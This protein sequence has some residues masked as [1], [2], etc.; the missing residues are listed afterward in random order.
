MCS[1][2]VNWGQTKM[3][4]DKGWSEDFENIQDR[5][6]TMNPDGATVQRCP[7]LMVV[8]RLAHLAMAGSS[9]RPSTR[10]AVGGLER[11][12]NGSVCI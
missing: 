10:Q 1:M 4:Q 7:R 12:P 8:G 11:S 9:G 3:G 6:K 5:R 2:G